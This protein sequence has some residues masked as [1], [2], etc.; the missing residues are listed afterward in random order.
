MVWKRKL[1]KFVQKKKK[2]GKLD[3]LRKERLKKKKKD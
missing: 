2:K 3:G 1:R